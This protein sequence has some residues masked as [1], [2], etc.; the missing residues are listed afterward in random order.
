MGGRLEAAIVRFLGRVSGVIQG[1]VRRR[2]LV[3]RDLGGI[4]RFRIL[5]VVSMLIWVVTAC[6]LADVSAV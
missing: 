5:L 1:V 3:E 2:W 6:Q 4:Y